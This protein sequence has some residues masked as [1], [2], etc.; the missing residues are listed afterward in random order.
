MN[1]PFVLLALVTCLFAAPSVH[2]QEAPTEVAKPSRTTKP[3]G[4]V[5][6]VVIISADGLRPDVLLRARSP[7]IR[8]LMESAPDAA[9]IAV[10]DGRI[11]LVN[12]RTE[13]LF[14]YPREELLGLAVHRDRS[15]TAVGDAE[16]RDTP[17]PGTQHGT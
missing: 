6:R 14:G 2:A 8:R 5:E 13:Q 9:L 3:I 4:A 10:R 16:R 15:G 7:N 1:R 11:V 17:R 12:A